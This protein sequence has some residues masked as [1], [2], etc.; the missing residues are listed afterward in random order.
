MINASFG[1]TETGS[2]RTRNEDSY[3]LD[4]EHGLIAVADGLGGLPN[5][6]H[7]S[8]MTL[9]I[10]RQKL[11][12]QPDRPLIE[13]VTEVNEETRRVGYELDVSG[14][15]TTLTMARFLP[16]KD[17]VE[18][19][20]VGDSA[21]Y[22]VRDDEVRLLT[23]EHTVAAR[24]VAAQFEEAAEAIPPS[25]HHTLT[26]CIG[27]E[28]YI[29]PQIIEVPIR[30][31]DRIFLLTDGVTKP[32]S[33]AQLEQALVIKDSLERV[34]QALTFRIEIAGSPDN[35]TIASVEI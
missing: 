22:L 33:E 21:A 19:A 13:V 23:I 17:T 4:V 8:R 5:G 25:A 26:Q 31:G 35:Y 28:L 3:L 9:D 16:G 15:G 11:V 12:R 14:F 32:V 30:K 7:A 18:I 20:H 24:M 10:L 1:L 6:A 29:D 34:C 2:V 27:Q